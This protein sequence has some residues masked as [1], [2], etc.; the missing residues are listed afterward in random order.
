[1][2]SIDLEGNRITNVGAKAQSSRGRIDFGVSRAL[3]L[4]ALLAALRGHESM[5]YLHVDGNND[6]SNE[7]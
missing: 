2:K 6:I 1:M 4:Q 7:A 3:G 5:T